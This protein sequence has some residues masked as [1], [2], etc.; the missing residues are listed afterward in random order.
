[1]IIREGDEG[2]SVFFL[3]KGDVDIT[4]EGKYLLTLDQPTAF[5]QNALESNEK[6]SASI[7]SKGVTKV[8]VLLKRDYNVIIRESKMFA[9]ELSL[10]FIRSLNFFFSW[11]DEDTDKLNKRIGEKILKP[12]EGIWQ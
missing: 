1:V 8:L 4:K 7:I 2:E 9:K 12:R 3:Y 6:R 11:K 5:G 10:K